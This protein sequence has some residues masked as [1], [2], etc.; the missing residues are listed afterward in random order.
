MDTEGFST[1][2]YYAFDAVLTLAQAINDTLAGWSNNSPD[3]SFSETEN[4]VNK[5]SLTRCFIRRKIRNININGTTVGQAVSIEAFT[6]FYLLILTI[7][8]K[9][10]L[11]LPRKPSDKHHWSP[12]VR[13]SKC[14]RVF[15]VNSTSN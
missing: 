10:T 14:V 7:S 4:E 3:W 12:S 15:V 6:C 2:S 11:Q 13:S 8:G 5:T 1:L 9:N